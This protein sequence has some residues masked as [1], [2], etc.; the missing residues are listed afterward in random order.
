MVTAENL[1][2]IPPFQI[3]DKF[4]TNFTEKAKIF[5]IDFPKQ[6]RVVDSLDRAN[7]GTNERSNNIQSA[8]NGISKTQKNLE[9]TKVHGHDNLSIRMIKLCE[10]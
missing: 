4:V 6:W 10:D 9:I 5:N 2:H 8:K 7:F 1:D 3:G